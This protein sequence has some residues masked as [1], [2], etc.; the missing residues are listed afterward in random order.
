MKATALRFFSPEDNSETKKKAAAPKPVTLTG[1]VSAAGKLVFPDKTVSQLGIDA[2][3]TRFKIGVQEGKR[4]I[5][6]LYLVAADDNAADSFEMSKAAKGYTIAL[7]LILQKSGID[8]A[9]TKHTFTIE[10]FTYEDGV[11]G[12]EL[13]LSSS[14][15]KPAYTGKPRGRKPKNSEVAA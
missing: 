12:F 15:P 1:Y 3:A 4:K 11:T 7:A 9:A 13:Q 2:D 10:P 14:A 5:K 8:Y 6:S